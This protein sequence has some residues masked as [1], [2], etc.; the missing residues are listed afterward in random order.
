MGQ[1][2]YIVLVGVVL[3]C[4]FTVL[5]AAHEF[6]HYL[7]ARMFN[8]GVEEFAIGFGKL[9]K[10]RGRPQFLTWMKRRYRVPMLPGQIPSIEHDEAPKFDLEATGSRPLDDISII[11]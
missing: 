6:G 7:C 11:D 5:V 2:F 9:P 1:F 4:M 8:M 10:K 3:L